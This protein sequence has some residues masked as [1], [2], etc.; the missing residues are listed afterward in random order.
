MEGHIAP[1]PSCGVN[2]VVDQSIPGV[3]GRCDGFFSSSS[4]HF[5]EK[6]PEV[7]VAALKEKLSSV[8]VALDGVNQKLILEHGRRRAAEI[9]SDTVKKKIARLLEKVDLLIKE[10]RYMQEDFGRAL[11]DKVAKAMSNFA[12]ISV[13]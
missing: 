5:N 12:A 6:Y 1:L 3:G 8:N 7:D 9:E 11:D 2:I 10:G 13:A 4:T